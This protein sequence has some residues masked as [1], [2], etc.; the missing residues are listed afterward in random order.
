[1]KRVGNLFPQIVAW[2]N[3]EHALR[4]ALIGK[5]KRA[6][7]R[8]FVDALPGSLET[9][10]ERLRNGLGPVGR[11]TEFVIH[12]PKERLISA[13]CFEDRVLH[14]AV[15]NVCEPVLERYQIYDSYACRSGKGQFAAIERACSY[16]RHH[17]WYLKL[18]VRKYF[19][20]IPRVRLWEQLRRFFREEAVLELW[21]Q[22]LDSWRPGAE[23]GLPIGALTSQHLAN[24]YLAEL[25]HQAKEAWRISGYVRY[26]D[27]S[28]WWFPSA[29]EARETRER[30]REFLRERLDL[31][32][33]PAFSNRTKLGMDFLGY[34]VFPWGSK[35]NRRSR[36]RFRD[37]WRALSG[38]WEAGDLEDQEFAERC[39][40]LVAFT[41]RAACKN[42]RAR[43][44]FGRARPRPCVRGQP[45][46]PRWQLEQQRQELPVGEP[47]QEHA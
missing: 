33:K 19:E 42:F 41:E 6:D 36:R 34:R 18:D 8:A 31:E 38:A 16:A 28:A 22:L 9:V 25:D 30:V 47:E 5:R 40:A 12:D 11:F 3:L 32:L 29:A 24:F 26:M 21:W 1:M 14:H 45:G 46:E 13:P 15:L 23:R 17:D 35:L 7:A 10:S 20:S 27:D 37:K 2:G 44:L 39:Q 4:R 43:V